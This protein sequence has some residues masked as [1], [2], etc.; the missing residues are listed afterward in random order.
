M[1]VTISER[2]KKILRV[3]ASGEALSR[4]TIERSINETRINTIRELNRLVKQ[5]FVASSGEARATVYSITQQARTVVLWNVEEY[6]AQEP[7]KRH[8]RYASL[9][10]ELFKIIK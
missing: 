8:A 9:E 4:P 10:P 3:L 5:G 1:N 2:S 6:L 7:D